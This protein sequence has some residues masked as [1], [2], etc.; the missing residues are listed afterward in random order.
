MI[1]SN[2]ANFKLIPLHY[3][4]HCAGLAAKRL[5]MCSLRNR[6]VAAESH[7]AAAA[8]APGVHCNTIKMYVSFIPCQLR[9][10]VTSLDIQKAEKPSNGSLSDTQTAKYSEKRMRTPTLW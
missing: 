4:A 10:G 1:N 8:N 2:K 7:E 5:L 9:L 6:Q 3:S